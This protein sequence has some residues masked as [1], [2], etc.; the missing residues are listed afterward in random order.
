MAY[1]L[2]LITSKHD[3]DDD[4]EG[5]L[6]LVVADFVVCVAQQVSEII[7]PQVVTGYVKTARAKV[8]L[9]FTSDRKQ[10]VD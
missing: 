4:N 6:F 3:D 5:V 1:H 8:S 9:R 2:I 10:R 7:Q